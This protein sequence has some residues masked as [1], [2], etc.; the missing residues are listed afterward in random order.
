[1][2]FLYPRT[3]S[4]YRSSNPSGAGLQPYNDP[5]QLQVV[6][7]GIPAAI[8]AKKE[9][10]TPPAGLPGDVRRRTYWNVEFRA[11]MGAVRNTD[12]IVDDL[13][14]RYQVTTA[15]WTPL[16]YNCLCETLES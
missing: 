5:N 16:G 2:S 13:G 9:L 15:Y 6:A 8:Q 3:I 12:V 4:I 1:M 11:T 10:S 7:A 14:L